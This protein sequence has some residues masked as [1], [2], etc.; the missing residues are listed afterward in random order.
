VQTVTLKLPVKSD[1][2]QALKETAEQFS[3]SFA[4]VCQTGWEAP[5][6]NGVDLHHATYRFERETTSLPSQLVCSARMKATEALKSAKAKLKKGKKASC[7]TGKAL[8]VRYDARSAT[9]RLDKGTAFLSSVEGRIPITLIV[10]DYYR[11][12][13]SWKVCSS[14]LCFK[15]DGRVF[16]HVVVST[17]DA[18]VEP[19]NITVGIDLGVN[20]PAVTSNADFI[21]ERQWKETT[22]KYFRIKRSLQSKGTDSAKRHLKKL[23]QKENRFRKDCDHVISRR[24]VDTV[25]PGSVVVL[26]DLVDIRGRVKAKRKQRRRIHSWSFE[27]LRSFLDYKGRMRSIA[28]EYVDPRYT[29]QKCSRCGYIARRNR[30]SQ[31]W[32]VCKSCGFQHNADLNASKNIRL[33]YL[34]SKGMSAGSRADVKQPIV[35]TTYKPPA[36]AGGI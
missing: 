17:D 35:S 9:I 2:L 26:E 34:A 22:K 10:C 3:Q 20:R 11:R 14:D 24:I 8:T 7:P 21:G 12:Y 4:R 6:V 27:R 13:L 31:S 5:R 33:N 15:R 36:L 25:V 28:I 19:T 23:S 29:S 18:V 16:L 1:K 32:F 30:Q